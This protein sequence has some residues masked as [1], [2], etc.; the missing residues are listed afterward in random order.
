VRFLLQKTFKSGEVDT[1][2]RSHDHGSSYAEVGDRGCSYS[3][4]H[5]PCYGFCQGPVKKLAPNTLAKQAY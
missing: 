3:I 4:G 2:A 5:V 1:L